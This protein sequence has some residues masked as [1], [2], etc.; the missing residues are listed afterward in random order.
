MYNLSQQALYTKLREAILEALRCGVSVG[1]I[2]S[3]LGQAQR[4]VAIAEPMIT[5]AIESQK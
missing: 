4:E 3:A 2:H 5:A 1:I